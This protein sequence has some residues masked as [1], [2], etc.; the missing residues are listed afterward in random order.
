MVPPRY[1]RHADGSIDFAF[2][3]RGAVRLRRRTTRLMFRRCAS[4]M[5]RS[6]RVIVSALALRDSVVKAKAQT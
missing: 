2:Y 1:R 5:V 6:A 3:R 4:A